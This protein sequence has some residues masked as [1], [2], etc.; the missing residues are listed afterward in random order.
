MPRDGEAAI[1]Q[2]RDARGLVVGVGSVGGEA[3]DQA[4]LVVADVDADVVVRACD[5]RLRYDHEA[6]TGQP[7]EVDVGQL[8]ER[9]VGR[10]RRQ[11]H[12]ASGAD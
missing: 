12:S 7:G 3:G 5:E 9:I 6:A 8:G 11:D 1:G 2:C 4:T 10:G